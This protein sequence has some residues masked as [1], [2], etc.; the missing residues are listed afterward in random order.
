MHPSLL[1]QVEWKDWIGFVKMTEA[2]IILWGLRSRFFF[3]YMFRFLFFWCYP[4]FSHPIYC[5]Y[6][7]SPWP[8]VCL[9][10]HALNAVMDWHQ[11]SHWLYIGPSCER[12]LTMKTS[13]IG[14]CMRIKNLHVA[15]QCGLAESKV[16]APG[17]QSSD[18]GFARPYI[19]SNSDLMSELQELKSLYTFIPCLAELYKHTGSTSPGLK[20]FILPLF[21]AASNTEIGVCS[22][23]QSV[24]NKTGKFMC[25]TL[26]Y[27]TCMRVH[28]VH[29][30]LCITVLK[31]QERN[32]I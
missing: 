23:L 9:T 31:M 6:Q 15:C 29:F 24:S 27:L 1:S 7:A 10:G 5:P 13:N 11:A 4:L 18:K 21:T 19:I 2:C 8:I 22:V 16:L 26:K 30:F 17:H 12:A 14:W 3:K 28:E 20:E 25:L 32:R